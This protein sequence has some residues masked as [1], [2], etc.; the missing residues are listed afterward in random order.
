[1]VAPKQEFLLV[2]CAV[3]LC[4]DDDIGTQT[5]ARSVTPTQSSFDPAQLLMREN[6]E[7]N[8]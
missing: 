8:E 1:M 6:R 3:G 4:S 7:N 2:H 5:Y